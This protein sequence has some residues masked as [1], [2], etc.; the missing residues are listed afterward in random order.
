[1]VR[2]ATKTAT[3]D[4]SPK[5]CPGVIHET[6]AYSIKEFKLRTGLQNRALRKAK[7]DG[8]NIR[9]VG[10]VRF[11]RGKDFIEFLASGAC[12]LASHG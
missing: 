1:M 8:L 11:V 3:D 2:K 5:F 6:S 4:G 7:A 10:N 9:K 12:D